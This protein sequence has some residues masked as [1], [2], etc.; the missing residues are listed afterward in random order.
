MF[1]VLLVVICVILVP[2]PGAFG[3][4]TV[5]APQ[6]AGPALSST[7][8][9]GDPCQDFL[10]ILERPQT[11][12]TWDPILQRDFAGAS[13]RTAETVWILANERPSGQRC[14]SALETGR[15][16]A[17]S[18]ALKKRAADTSRVI[19]SPFDQFFPVLCSLHAAQ[20]W[21]V[22]W[23]AKGLHAAPECL[24]GLYDISERPDAAPAVAGAVAEFPNWG[25]I[26]VVSAKLSSGVRAQL[27]P[28]LGAAYRTRP[29]WYRQFWDL[30]CGPTDGAPLVSPEECSRFQPAEES[31]SRQ[32]ERHQAGLR[33]LRVGLA[34]LPA[35][36]VIAVDAYYRNEESGR[37]VATLSAGAGGAVLGAWLGS[38]VAEA[39]QGGSGGGGGAHYGDPIGLIVGVVTGIAGAT[40]A[41]LLTYH[42]TADSPTGRVAVT[43]TSMAIV[44]VFTIS[45]VWN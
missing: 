32:S 36:G 31:W 18:A 11:T 35:A 21:A 6:S 8:D 13:T 1:C 26:Y 38:Q 41:S 2:S 28:K 17:L 23:I 34:A 22:S 40:A 27:A 39:A 12:L 45:I 29:T 25:H 19:W 30:A 9:A 14:R 42:L 10:N 43:S 16:P 44:S 7:T 15:A 37:V 5:A 20:D 4:E 24:A 3:E 33:A